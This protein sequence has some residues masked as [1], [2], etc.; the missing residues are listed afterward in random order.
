MSKY[1]VCIYTVYYNR[2]NEVDESIQS[3]LDQS[4]DDFLVV[5]I[6][7]GSTDQTLKKLKKFSNDSRLKI[8]SKANSGF[9]DSIKYAISLD[10][11]EYIAI[12]GSG[13]V[14]FPNRIS[15][16]VEILEKKQNV[17]VVGCHYISEDLVSKKHIEFSDISGLVVD[18][19]KKLKKKNFLTHGEVMFRRNI[20]DRVGGYNTLFYYSQDYDLWL[21]MSKLTQFYIVPDFLYKRYVRADGVSGKV[22]KIIPQQYLASF[23]RTNEIAHSNDIKSVDLLFK[24]KDKIYSKRLIKLFFRSAIYGSVDDMNTALK[25]IKIECN[26][27]LYITFIS[28]GTL[29]KPIKGLI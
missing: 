11:S 16:Q 1:K 20:Y 13:D 8:I 2:E 5:A 27:F 15:S 21:R 3:L 24:G 26:P 17:G 9:V 19:N 12:H 14:S 10:E 25:F 29:I 28:I 18:V 22:S 6:D 4:Y 23:A 7:D